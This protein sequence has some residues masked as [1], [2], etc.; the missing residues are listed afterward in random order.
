MI[1]AKELFDEC[2]CQCE[3]IGRVCLRGDTINPGVNFPKEL[4]D[5]MKEKD[6]KEYSLSCFSVDVINE[7]TALLY[8]TTYNGDYTELGVVDNAA[9]LKKYYL[10][11]ANES[12]IRET[13]FGLRA[14]KLLTKF[15]NNL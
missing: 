1:I 2:F 6:G 13:G 15:T 8:Y 10:E 4:V 5:K 9:E 3:G 11:T 7:S 12:E 14:I